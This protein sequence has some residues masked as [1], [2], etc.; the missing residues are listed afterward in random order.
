MKVH[1]LEAEDDAGTNQVWH[2]YTCEVVLSDGLITQAREAARRYAEA[3]HPLRWVT[4]WRNVS[5]LVG[6]NMEDEKGFRT[7]DADMEEL[8]LS[9]QEMYDSLSESPAGA[10]ILQYFVGWD[11]HIPEE[12]PKD[13][14]PGLCHGFRVS[15]DSSRML[16]QI[17]PESREVHLLEQLFE[18][19]AAK[20]AEAFLDEHVETPSTSQH[21]GARP[22]PRYV[23]EGWVLPFRLETQD[24]EK[25]S[26][27]IDHELIARV[28][29]LFTKT[30]ARPGEPPPV[31]VLEPGCGAV[32][33]EGVVH[34][35]YCV[36]ASR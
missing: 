35:K 15:H 29:P 17:H 10:G 12:K 13:F 24:I 20:A 18:Y 36:A 11:A 21:E 16:M 14:Y 23:L 26:L 33:Y 30:V 34:A 32:F 1:L 28:G 31:P 9:L 5:L 19:L 27:Q 4:T 3:P 2:E 7:D 25:L 6:D 22:L 8:R